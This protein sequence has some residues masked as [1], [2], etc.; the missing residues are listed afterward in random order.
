MPD[1]I[2]F[3]RVPSPAGFG[4]ASVADACDTIIYCLSRYLWITDNK[5]PP[6]RS[7]TEVSVHTPAVPPLLAVGPTTHSAEPGHHSRSPASRSHITAESPAPPTQGT[8]PPFGAQLPEPFPAASDTG[9][10]ASHRLS[11]IA[12][13][14][15]LVPIRVVPRF[16][17]RVI[18][19]PGPPFCQRVPRQCSGRPPC[20]P[21]YGYR[22]HEIENGGNR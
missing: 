17:C 1:K 12:C 16:T 11:A 8:R 4:C 15:V 2:L 10:A 14:Q 20:R 21:C 9:V 5:K 13:G 6:S 22:A 18:L 3:L 7:G 19:A